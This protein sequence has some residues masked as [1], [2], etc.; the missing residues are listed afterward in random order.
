MNDL[1]RWIC[2]H[3]EIALVKLDIDRDESS[4]PWLL[5]MPGEVSDLV[6][7]RTILTVSCDVEQPDA[8]T[9]E[10]DARMEHRELRGATL[11]EL[12]SDDDGTTEL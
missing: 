6:G 12:F 8:P 5:N 10:Q 3:D 9:M 4:T 11:D 7:P 2:E 1:F